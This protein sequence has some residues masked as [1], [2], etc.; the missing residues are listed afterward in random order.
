[1][2]GIYRTPGVHIETAGERFKPLE[3][4]RTGVTA[5]LGRTS[6]GASQSPVKVD[7][8]DRYCAVFGNDGGTTCAA[9]R[10]FFENGG[11]VAYVVN[12]TPDDGRGLTPDDF[13]GAKGPKGLR[14][15]ERLDDV[16]LVVAPDLVTLPGKELAFPGLDAVHA[17]QRAMVDHC[18]R[19]QDRFALLDTPA[20]ASLDA[21]VQWRRRFDTSYAALYYPWVVARVG[22]E[23]G[24]PVPPSGHVAGLY[25]K[26]DAE[27]GVHRAPANLPLQGL[28]DTSTFVHKRE[29]DYLFDNEVNGIYPFPARGIRPWG[30]RTL[31]SDKAFAHVNVRR[32]FIMLRRSIDQFAQ[33][34]VFEPNGPQLWKQLTRAVEAFLYKLYK[35]GAIVGAAPEEAFF[36]KCDEETNPP[37][38][39][40]AGEL[41]IE[42]GVAPVKPAEFIVVRIH[43]WT[44]EASP[45]KTVADAPGAG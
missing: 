39:R 16:D 17:V 2:G 41:V 40:D 25:A 5:F 21:A 37:E 35:K 11:E 7:S 8:F 26:C 27:S 3:A 23:A 12:V 22:T 9:V 6:G 34:V 19:M 42:V 45:D 20:E 13:I 18:E 1:M 38:A 36:V 30:S 43:Q 24:E 10:G 44:R 14:L 33:W 31:A 29:R 4:A 28:V 32:L 15:L